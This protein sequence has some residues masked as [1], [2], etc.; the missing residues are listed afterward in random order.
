MFSKV[1]IANRGEIAVRVIRACRELGVAT[2][3]I[4]SEADRGALHVRLADEAHVC[5]PAPARDSYL[6]AERVLEIATRCG[7]DAIH[8]GYG[9]LSENGDFADLCEQRGIRFIG[10]PGAVIRA[11]GDKITARPVKVP[12]GDEREITF[13]HAF[14]QPGEVPCAVE[15]APDELDADNRRFLV[16]TVRD[17][18]VLLVN[19]RP[20]RVRSKPSGRA[21]TRLTTP[22]LGPS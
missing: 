6:V 21:L 7:A 19:G 18:P 17:I 14:K 16:V 2:V 11:M 15:L 10:P 1:L 20:S 22:F 8:P 9:F 12:F 3:A 4:H 13:R 5:G